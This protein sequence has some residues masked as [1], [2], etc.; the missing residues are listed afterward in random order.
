MTVKIN[1]LSP[2]V[3]RVLYAHE[4]SMWF[5]THKNPTNTEDI[6]Q[7]EKDIVATTYEEYDEYIK[8]K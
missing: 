6:K 4:D 2:G 7:L 3:K 5:N 1:K 8:N